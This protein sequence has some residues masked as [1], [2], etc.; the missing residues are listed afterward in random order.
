MTTG[1]SQWPFGL[2]AL[3]MGAIGTQA[4]TPGSEF[5]TNTGADSTGWW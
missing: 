5:A 2:L 4:A 3:L 1:A